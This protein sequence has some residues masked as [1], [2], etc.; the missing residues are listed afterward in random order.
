MLPVTCIQSCPRYRL[1]GLCLALTCGPGP[2][3]GLYSSK[4]QYKSKL[5]AKDFT[6]FSGKSQRVTVNLYLTDMRGSKTPKCVSLG[7]FGDISANPCRWWIFP[8]APTFIQII[9]Q[10]WFSLIYVQTFVVGFFNHSLDYSCKNANI[11]LLPK[12]NLFVSVGIFQRQQ[13]W[14]M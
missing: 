2:P 4:N 6:N 7:N 3:F 1:K 13:S 14:I 8:D 9:R 10:S 5:S 12:Q 11:K